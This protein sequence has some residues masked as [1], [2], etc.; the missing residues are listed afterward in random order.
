MW[1]TELF[2]PNEVRRIKQMVPGEVNDCYV[3]AHSRHKA[4]TVK[5]GYEMLAKAKSLVAGPI[6]PEEQVRNALKRRIW[7]IPIL[8][9]IQM[10]L[11]RAVSGALAVAERLNSRGLGVDTMCKLCQGGSE[12]INHVLY[13]CSVATRVW[14]DARNRLPVASLQRSLE[15]NLVFVFNLME[16]KSRPQTLVRF[17]PWMLWSVWKNKNSIVYAETQES[18]ERLLRDMVNEVDQWFLLNTAPP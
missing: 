14:S 3:W 1:L 7:K 15:E 11:W 4:Y 17:V 13:Q 2:P 16:D 10:F 12:T 5:T 9:K 8:P 6:P 18:M